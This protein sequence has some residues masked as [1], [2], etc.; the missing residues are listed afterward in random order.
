MYILLRSLPNRRPRLLLNKSSYDLPN[1]MIAAIV[2]MI[3]IASIK[4]LVTFPSSLSPILSLFVLFLSFFLTFYYVFFVL[5]STLRTLATY[6]SIGIWRYESAIWAYPMVCIIYPMFAHVSSLSSS[7]SRIGIA[8]S[9]HI[10]NL[11]NNSLYV[12]LFDKESSS[13]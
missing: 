12:G 5:K 2:H 9:K 3:R 8:V 11:S 6:I 4:Y 13:A 7:A 10:L 1:L